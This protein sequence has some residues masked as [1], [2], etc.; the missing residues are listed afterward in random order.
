MSQP[1]ATPGL[2]LVVG[3]AVG[4]GLLAL[5]GAALAAT[6]AVPEGFTITTFATA[7]L[8]PASTG[9]DDIARLDGHVFVGFQNAV[10]KTGP[11]STGPQD[12]TIGEFNG[13]GSLL[14]A[15]SVRGRVDG[16]AADPANNRLVIT[17]N[18][19][20]NS[21]IHTLAPTAPVGSQIVDYTYSPNP[22]AS[23]NPTT[24]NTL[25]T[26]GGTDSVSIVDGKIFVAAS[27]PN[28]LTSAANPNPGA[29]AVFRVTLRDT[30][31]DLSPTFPDDATAT[32]GG[33]GSGT[34]QLALTDPDST[35]TVP[36]LAPLFGGQFVL[37]GQADQQLI[38]VKGIAGASPLTDAAITQLPLTHADPANPGSTIGAGVDDVRWSAAAG[39]TLIA[40]DNPTSTIYAISGPFS[41]FEA[42]AS[43]DTIGADSNTTEIDTLNTESGLLTPFATGFGVVKGLLW[44]P[45]PA[46]HR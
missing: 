30:T 24:D 2:G 27:N 4:L 23:A 34:T 44:Y 15:F 20:G 13:D 42:F 46:S 25:Q 41:A 29:T 19:D 32:V 5:P 37:D 18:E 6:P 1:Q 43:L 28:D 14:A 21:A 38:F 7:P 9:A 36:A 8:A 3:A 31:A 16:M 17:T 39:G 10:P 26:G 12:S 40:V 35:A 11:G 45:T 22:S 33:G